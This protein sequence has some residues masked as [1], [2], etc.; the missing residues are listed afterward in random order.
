MRMKLRLPQLTK[1]TKIN[2]A[3]DAGCGCKNEG[4]S[5]LREVGP[6][7][8]LAEAFDH[9]GEQCE[10]CFVDNPVLY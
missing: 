10:F 7:L 4:L 5:I 3:A 1:G 8:G 9:E 6:L 2:E